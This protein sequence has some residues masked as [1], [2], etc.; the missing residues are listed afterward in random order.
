MRKEQDEKPVVDATG[1]GLGVRVEPV[2]GVS[3]VDVDDQNR[4]ILNGKGL[5]VAPNWRE[6]PFFL[7]PKRLQHQVKAARGSASLFC[8]T[9]GDG[10]FADDRVAEQL[11]LRVD[12]P[13]HGCVVPSQLVSVERFQADLA[14]TR[15]DWHI[16]ED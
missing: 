1:K 11:S 5:S 13:N 12:R 14:A 6:L 9:M 10:A 4:V 7:I 15:D 2:R 3:D 16:D 8:F